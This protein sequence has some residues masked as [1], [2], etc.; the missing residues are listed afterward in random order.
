MRDTLESTLAYAPAYT[1]AA[2]LAAMVDIG[3]FH[4]LSHIMSGVLLPAVLSFAAAAAVNYTLSTVWV[5]SRDWRSMRRAMLF[6][7]FACLGLALNASMTWWL[8]TSLPVHPT[9]AKVGG[10]ATAFGV[11]FLVNTHLV[12]GRGA[13]PRASS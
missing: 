2:G 1:L 9:L 11:N 10:V 5:Y 12:F 4:V 6:L 13:T 3:G 7:L 8:A